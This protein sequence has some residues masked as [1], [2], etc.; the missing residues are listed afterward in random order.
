VN[1]AQREQLDRGDAV[2][3]EFTVILDTHIDELFEFHYM[4]SSYFAEEA[5]GKEYSRRP[6]LGFRLCGIGEPLT[7]IA[8]RPAW[9]YGKKVLDP[10]SITME[11]LV[12][13]NQGKRDGK[14]VFRISHDFSIVLTANDWRWTSF[15]HTNAIDGAERIVEVVQSFLMC[16][17]DVFARSKTHCSICGRALTDDQ[18]RTRGIGPECIK[19]TRFLEVLSTQ[20]VL[21]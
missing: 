6:P 3:R 18:S 2:R 20:S 15:S 7:R 11:T 9:H 8:V 21:A 10:H 13:R 14:Q 4:I 19:K 17:D 1:Q 12:E 16:R 5:Q